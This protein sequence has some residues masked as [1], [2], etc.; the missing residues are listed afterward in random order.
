MRGWSQITEIAHVFGY[1]KKMS[2]KMDAP[3][4]KMLKSQVLGFLLEEKELEISEL[5]HSSFISDA[6]IKIP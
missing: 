5:H 6:L 4:S 1:I 2:F 3:V